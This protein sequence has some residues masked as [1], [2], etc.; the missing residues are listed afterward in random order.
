MTA[1]GHEATLTA[2]TAA[3]LWHIEVPV[4]SAALNSLSRRTG[5]PRRP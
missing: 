5:E 1:V 3:A 2:Y 4:A